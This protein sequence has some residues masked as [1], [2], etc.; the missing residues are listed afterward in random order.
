MNSRVSARCPESVACPE[1]GAQV[2][3][4]G[5]NRTPLRLSADHTVDFIDTEQEDIVDAF[6]TECR[7][8]ARRP[9]TAS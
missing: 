2:R 6:I 4:L 1:C 8:T 5:P 7:N 3:V 9:R